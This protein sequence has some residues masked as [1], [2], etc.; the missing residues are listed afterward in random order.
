MALPNINNTKSTP[1]TSFSGSDITCVIGNTI[2]GTLQAISYSVTREK[3]P[4]YVMRGSP[5][6]RAFARGKRAIA[7]SLVFVT[8]DRQSFLSHMEE[9]S[10]GKGANFYGNVTDITYDFNDKLTPEDVFGLFEAQ[11]TDENDFSS[12]TAGA[13]AGY[14]RQEVKARYADQVLPFDINISASNELGQAM[15]RSFI[16]VEIL[17]EGGGVS[18]DDLVIEEQYTFIARDMTK[19]VKVLDAGQIKVS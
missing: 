14:E 15:K 18:I 4:I 2:V 13:G 10:G 19:W 3:G 17:N 1:F 11:L 6:P 5:N 16:G 8:I 12:V 7:G 9:T